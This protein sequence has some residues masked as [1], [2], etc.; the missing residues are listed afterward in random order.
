MAGYVSLFSLLA[1]VSRTTS[2]SH[3]NFIT[4]EYILIVPCESFLQM[5]FASFMEKKN[6]WISVICLQCCVHP[7]V[8]GMSPMKFFFPYTLHHMRSIYSRIYC[9]LKMICFT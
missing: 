7:C 1:L 8:F 5:G 9:I 4:E 2:L 3:L 6:H